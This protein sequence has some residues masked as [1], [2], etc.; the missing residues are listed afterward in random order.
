VIFFGSLLRSFRA[1]RFW[2]ASLWGASLLAFSENVV[3]VKPLFSL[4][5]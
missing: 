1:L 2:L 3:S 5:H 4:R